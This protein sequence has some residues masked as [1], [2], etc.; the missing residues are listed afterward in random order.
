M[1]L[2]INIVFLQ[3]SMK[4]VTHQQ[5]HIST[6]CMEEYLLFARALNLWQNIILSREHEQ[7]VVAPPS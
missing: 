7:E 1:L 4:R 3:Q 6:I 2:C 5:L